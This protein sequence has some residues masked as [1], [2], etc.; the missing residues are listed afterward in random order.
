MAYIYGAL[1]VT[2]TSAVIQVSRKHRNVKAHDGIETK[3]ESRK[4]SSH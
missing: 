3:R 4:A 2:Y 1:T